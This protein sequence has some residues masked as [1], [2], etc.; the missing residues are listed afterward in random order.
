[1][2]LPDTPEWNR[3]RD[4]ALHL[5]GSRYKATPDYLQKLAALKQGDPLPPG[6]H[7]DTTIQQLAQHALDLEQ[8]IQALETALLVEVK[9]HMSRP[10]MGTVW[11]CSTCDSEAEGVTWD[12]M[13]YV[14]ECKATGAQKLVELDAIEAAP[15][16]AL[17]DEQAA[18]EGLWSTRLDGS[19]SITEAHLQH[20][21]RRLHA[22]IESNRQ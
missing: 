2:T 9:G 5:M 17:V 14:C 8:R 11:W 18:D 10:K 12:G 22:L 21:L 13:E 1:M 19:T 20:E 15:L 7:P 16:Y 4:I 3:S 6:Y